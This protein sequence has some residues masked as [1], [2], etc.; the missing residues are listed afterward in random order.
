MEKTAM[1]KKEIQRQNWSEAELARQESGLTVTQWCR[2]ERISENRNR[3]CGHQNCIRRTESRDLIG[4]SFRKDCCDNWCIEML[5]EILMGA[6]VYIV[7]GYTDMRK[8][9]DGLAQIVEGS[10]GKDVY[11]KAVYLFCGRSNTKIKALVWDG[12]GF[13]FT[14]GW[15]TD[16]IVGREQS[17]KQSS[18]PHSSF[19]G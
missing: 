7:T 9:I 17:A 5:T 18:L 4:C 10:V 19:A 6:T 13:C 3:P 1:F 2:Q 16:A 15:I 11:S 8:G 14:K 12:D